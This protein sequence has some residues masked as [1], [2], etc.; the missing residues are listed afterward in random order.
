MGDLRACCADP[1]NLELIPDHPDAKPDDVIHVQTEAGV[2]D[3]PASRTVQ[4]CQKCGRRHF[5]LSA[6]AGHMGVAGKRV[7]GK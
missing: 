3:V 4:V 2:V 6:D 5:E 1:E 7:V